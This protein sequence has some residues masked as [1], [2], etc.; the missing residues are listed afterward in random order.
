MSARTGSRGR[1]RSGDTAVADIAAAEGT[2]LRPQRTR[3]PRAPV[4]GFRQDYFLSVSRHGFH[5]IAYTDWGHPEAERGVVVCV[6]GLTRQGRDFDR[7]AAELARRGFRV[8]CPD[9]PGRGRSDWL[10]NPDDYELPQ[11][12]VDMTAMIAR[13]GAPTVDWVGTSLGGL[14]GMVMA[15][16][17]ESPIRR[18]VVNDIGP[19]LPWAA[20]KRIGEGLAQQP[21]EFPDLE[22]AV[23]FFRRL[24]QPFG[25][26]SE[27][28]WRHLAIHSVEEIEPGGSCRMLCDPGIAKAFRPVRA[29]NLNLWHYWNSIT[30][31]TLLL[32][33]ATSDL[34]PSDVAADMTR[35]GPRPELV[36][37]AE[38]GH[39][40]ALLDDEQLG[41]I[42]DWLSGSAAR[43]SQL[44]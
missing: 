41:T 44:A 18:L 30:A 23:D 8:I 10:T 38:C 31:P 33:G 42:C 20:L 27:E 4:P 1:R 36:E 13:I 5:R 26:L 34:L 21:R 29:F 12:V 24:L 11:F 17:P 19:V 3:P 40:P 32:R 25:A 28:E 35:R 7:L 9:L 15:G 39:A 22:A 2:V 16:H 14:I 37:F 6:H 43:R